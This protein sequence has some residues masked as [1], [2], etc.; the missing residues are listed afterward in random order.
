MFNV[1]FYICVSLV[2]SNKCIQYGYQPY[3][4][5]HDIAFNVKCYKGF[6]FIFFLEKEIYI[7]NTQKAQ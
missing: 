4:F 2:K 7:K 1:S 6:L 5:T 3:T